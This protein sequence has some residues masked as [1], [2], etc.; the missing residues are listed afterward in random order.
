M[1]EEQTANTTTPPE[2]GSTDPASETPEGT[3]TAP[4]VEELMAERERM[5]VALKA[6]NR[7]AADRR[8]KLDAY[9][10]AEAKRKA[11]EMTDLEKAQAERA[12]FETRYQKLATEFDGLRL[13]QSF[14]DEVAK[15][16]VQFASDQARADAY[17]LA[18]LTAALDGGEVQSKAVGDALKAL[19][20]DRPYLFG[21][22]AAPPDIGA[23][24]RGGDSGLPDV[25]DADVQEFAA[26][27]SIPVQYVDK[28]ALAQLKRVA[29]KGK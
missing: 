9:E 17:N 16:G 22:P 14:F 5:S 25:T 26:R 24:A 1:A 23:T 15:Q 8:K 27:M 13:R 20:R 3:T 12:E 4:T 10:Q 19:K 28:R 29:S 18:D 21:Q 2:T 11:A 7:E 6:A